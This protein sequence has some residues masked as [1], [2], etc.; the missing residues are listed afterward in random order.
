MKKYVYLNTAKQLAGTVLF[1]LCGIAQAGFLPEAIQLHG[2]LTQ[3]FFHSSNNNVYGQSDDGISPGLTEIGLN[4]A[5]QPFN[6]LRFAAQG[7]YRRGGAVD[8]SSARLDYGLADLTLWTYKSGQIGIRGGRIKIPFGLYNETRDVPFT[9]PT[10]LLPQGIYFDRSRSL[11]RSADGG[12]FYIDQRTNYGNFAFKFNVGSPLGNHQ[13]IRSSIL[14]P[15]A[16]GEFEGQPGMA[17]QLNYEINGGEYIFAVSYMD[18]ELD[19]QPLAGEPLSSGKAHIQ[20]LLFSAQYNGEKFTLTAE[21]DYRWNEL[22]HFGPHVPDFN[23]I[24]ESWYI[25]GSYQFLAQLQATVRYDV[26]YNNKDDKTGKRAAAFGLPNHIAY[27]TDWTFGLRYDINTSWM[28]R[29]DY[30]RIHGTAWL[31]QADNPDR[32]LTVQ[33][34]NLYGLQISFKF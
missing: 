4:A 28:L 18:L 29:A 8:D 5:Y 24:T 17:T 12:S 27:A 2:F 9:H 23:S 21:Y 33:D 11:L 6:R 20:P 13:E 7:L 31:S 34:W 16:Q 15:N 10:I 30:H 19:Y 25:Q 32:Q 26:L 1:G 14:G 3:G 22:S